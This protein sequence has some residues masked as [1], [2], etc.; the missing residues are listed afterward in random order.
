LDIG[1]KSSDNHVVVA[2]PVALED[3]K[4]LRW[5]PFGTSIVQDCPFA[6]AEKPKISIDLCKVSLCS[7]VVLLQLISVILSLI[8]SP[9]LRVS[10]IRRHAATVPSLPTRFCMAAAVP[11]YSKRLTLFL[12]FSP[13]H[14]QPD[15]EQTIPVTTFLLSGDSDLLLKPS[16]SQNQKLVE[17]WCKVVKISFHYEFSLQHQSPY[18]KKLVKELKAFEGQVEAGPRRMTSDFQILLDLL[19]FILI[20]ALH[21]NIAF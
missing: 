10:S 15:Y 1:S 20:L 17:E 3:D 14:T 2:L 6:W 19:H 12:L 11:A 13:P 8:S 5:I 9:A 21:E 7:K 4:R 18:H 16:D